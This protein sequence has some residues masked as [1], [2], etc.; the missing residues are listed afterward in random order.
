MKKIGKWKRIILPLC[1]ALTFADVPAAWAAEGTETPDTVWTE[2]AT[3]APA[4]ST[5][6]LQTETLT[7]PQTDTVPAITEWQTETT[8]GFSAETSTE[9]QTDPFTEPTESDPT[10]NQVPSASETE[11]SQQTESQTA[12]ET[13]PEGCVCETVSED[14]WL[15]SW[16]CTVFQDV[17]VDACSCGADSLYPFEHDEMCIGQWRAMGKICTCGVGELPYNYHAEECAC[18][19]RLRMLLCSCQESSND[20]V[21]HGDDCGYAVFLLGGEEVGGG[22]S[23]ELASQSGSVVATQALPN[24]EYV[25]IP[26][27]RSVSREYNAIRFDAGESGYEL[28]GQA[29]ADMVLGARGDY[30]DFWQPLTAPENLT[31]GISSYGARYTKVIFNNEDGYWYDI[32]IELCGYTDTVVYKDQVKDG[33]YPMVAFKKHAVGLEFHRCGNY[34]IRCQFM[35]NGTS[36]PAKLKV[37]LNFTDLDSRQIFGFKTENGSIDHRYVTDET[38]VSLAD[39]TEMAGISGLSILIGAGVES[40]RGEETDVTYD[41]NASGFYVGVGYGNNDKFSWENLNTVHYSK[42]TQGGVQDL[43]NATS[44]LVLIS[45]PRIIDPIQFTVTYHF[46]DGSLEPA[47]VE[48]PAAYTGQAGS[49]YTV[50]KIAANPSLWQG[51]GL[52]EQGIQ[53]KGWNYG[54]DMKKN[55]IAEGETVTLDSDIDLYINYSQG[56]YSIEYRYADGSEQP[57]GVT[58]PAGAAVSPGKTYTVESVPQAA[59]YIAEGWY[60]AADRTGTRTEPGT[61]ITVNGNR[62]FYVYYGKQPSRALAVTKT[63]AVTGEIISDAEFTVYEW[64]GSSYSCTAGKLA[65]QAEKKRY[66][67]EGLYRT[68][69][70]D[71]RYRVVETLVP[72]GFSGAWSMEFAVNRTDTGEVLELSAANDMQKGILVIQKKSSGD[73]TFLAGA[74]YQIAAA[75]DIVSP[76]GK[77]LEKKGTVLET[78][79]TGE[80]G[81]A[82]SAALYPGR[83]LVTEIKAP[84]G[85]ALNKEPQTVEIAVSQDAAEQEYPVTF[86]D[87][88]LYAELTITKELDAEDIVWAHGNPAFIFKAEGEDAL[89]NKHTYYSAVEFTEGTVGTDGKVTVSTQLTVPAGIY[90]VTEEKTMRYSLQ[91][92]HN[93]INGKASGSQ[94]VFDLTDGQPGAATFYNVKINDE[95]AGHTALVKN[96]IG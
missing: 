37:R 8:S 2:G 49:S 52:A 38:T 89:G 40:E 18:V 6:D 47:G 83:Y 63:N 86:L 92:I 56:D 32:Y 68:E 9:L 42:T 69:E 81:R 90:T 14:G 57:A 20:P 78:V 7:E 84:A 70:N 73:G 5:G 26:D 15:H 93:V 4:G 39:A 87:E 44:E 85:Y 75:E 34:V 67:I 50:E 1:A 64:D 33:V 11:N 94:V 61:Q 10:E 12:G 77:T 17:F 88:R 51:L 19:T 25:A 13:F 66:Y 76:G 3:E 79:A 96:H 45:Q 62:I 58:L 29:T 91:G 53:V 74:E 21:A 24:G 82:K 95:G 60:A 46:A 41:I 36:T 80:D 28:R 30:T 71:G 23:L 65:Y 72:A 27:A 43:T 59:D 31:N 16:E 48:L 35:R 54:A 22:G 55:W